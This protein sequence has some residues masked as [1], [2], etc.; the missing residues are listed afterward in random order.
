MK[1]VLKAVPWG[2]VLCLNQ[3]ATGGF[4]ATT[5]NYSNLYLIS[6]TSV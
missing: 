2:T 4:Y 5:N 3:K 1:D 6:I